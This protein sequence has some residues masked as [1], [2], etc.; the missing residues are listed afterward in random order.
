MEV[1]TWASP[2]TPGAGR[3]P[4]EK[5]GLTERGREVSG[6]IVTVL[7]VERETRTGGGRMWAW[8]QK[9]K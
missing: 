3:R 9:V 4:N 7:R 8:E 1:P 6:G 2:W 5:I